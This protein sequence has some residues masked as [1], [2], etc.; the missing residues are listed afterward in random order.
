MNSVLIIYASCDGHTRDICLFLQ[1][2]MSR[3]GARI[4]LLSVDSYSETDLHKADAIIIGASIRYGKHSAKITQLCTANQQVLA[5]KKNAFFSVNAVARKPERCDVSTNP[6][7]AKFLKN[8]SWVP[9]HLAIFGGKIN[10]AQYGFVDKYMI[11]AI[12]W[13]TKGPTDLNSCTD[14]TNWQNVE[15]FADG[16]ITH[17]NL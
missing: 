10:Y 17:W 8:I 4:Q 15:K 11:Q 14:F 7:L 13:L 16:L 5:Q 6:Y 12:M 9:Q 1:Q 3:N 2:Y